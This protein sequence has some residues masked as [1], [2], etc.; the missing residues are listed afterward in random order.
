MAYCRECGQPIKWIKRR[1]GWRP[2]NQG[3]TK[4]HFETCKPDPEYLARRIEEEELEK[5]L[6]YASY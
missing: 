3:D 6:K 5:E 4:L 1:G 2:Y